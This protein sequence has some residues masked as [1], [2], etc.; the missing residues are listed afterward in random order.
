MNNPKIVKPIIC[1]FGLFCF[2]LP[3]FT[4]TM[5]LSSV[6]SYMSF[7][8]GLGNSALSEIAFP[9]TGAELFAFIQWMLSVLGY[10]GST[11]DPVRVYMFLG[12]AWLAIPFILIGMMG[13]WNMLKQDRTT[14][15]VTIVA[16]AVN[17]VIYA[18][19]VIYLLANPITVSGVKVSGSFGLWFLLIVN[20]VM[21][22]LGIYQKNET[23]RQRIIDDGPAS[24]PIE[25]HPAPAPAPSPVQ[26]ESGQIVGI[27]GQYSGSVINIEP[28]GEIVI[29]RDSTSCNL[30]VSGAK[31][32]RKHC[33]IKYDPATH[34]YRV[35]DYS[36][37]G[38]YTADGKRLLAN[39]YSSL[40]KGT[41]IYLGDQSIMFRLS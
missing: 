41:T 1:L 38:T 32:S 11:A 4:L 23:Y 9:V 28:R 15:I 22:V 17:T 25:N 20:A 19:S 21:L 8:S 16:S 37:N 31:V 13:V 27:N 7:F 34:T 10:L 24:R 26:E 30:I 3:F 6:T 36:T 39:Q 2:V 35:I 12:F 33:G 29:G 18:A 5:S 40:P 14:R